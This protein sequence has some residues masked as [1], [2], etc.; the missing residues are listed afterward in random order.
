MLRGASFLA[1][2]LFV[3]STIF[4]ADELPWLADVTTPPQSI[5]APWKPVT[6]LLEPGQTLADWKERR[7]TLAEEW[8]RVLGP[9]PDRPAKTTWTVRQ[10]ELVGDVRRE[11]VEF[12]GEP[13][14]KARAYIL[15][16]AAEAS[17]RSR[18]GVVV[19]HPTTTE[20]FLPVAGVTGEPLRHS[21][22]L[23]ARQGYVVVCPECFLW[24][25]ADD[26]R[27]AVANH[28]R[29]HPDALG[30]AKMLYDAQR[31]VDLLLAQSDV[32]PNRI[33]AFGHSLGAKEVLYLTA[34]DDRIQVGVA[35]E[36]GIA[37]NSTNWHDAWYLGPI[38]RDPNWPRDHHELLALIAPR[39]FLVI[40]GETG[41][42]A[43]DGTRSWPCLKEAQSIYRLYGEPVRL[44]LL[45]HGSGHP[46]TPA[47]W[48]RCI[49]WLNQSLK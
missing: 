21:G 17:S 7:P 6:S 28:Q 19:L 23:L 16:P 32:D 34:L 18:P 11:L 9:M 38:A 5:P 22:L 42:G 2:I 44:G 30:M 39:P 8:R 3:C 46:L 47:A 15:R 36:G 29:K 33:G 24:V 27:V 10:S 14:T 4:A 43:A 12:E 25:D 49:E 41:P 45:N 20:T 13:G 40:G 35:S 48:D 26:Y 1:C 37:L 31:G